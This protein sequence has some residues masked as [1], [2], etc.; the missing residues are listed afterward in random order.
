MDQSTNLPE[1]F[2]LDLQQDA[3][4]LLDDSKDFE[5]WL[6]SVTEFLKHEHLDSLLDTRV[7]RPEPTSPNYQKWERYSINARGW[8]AK[9]MSLQLFLRIE[10]RGYPIHLADEFI[11]NARII[12]RESVLGAVTMEVGPLLFRRRS[13]FK[14]ALEYV[15]A[16]CDH[17]IASENLKTYINPCIVLSRIFTELRREIPDFIEY[18]TSLVDAY[19]DAWNKLII[20]DVQEACTSIIAHLKDRSD[21][22]TAFSLLE[23]E[24]S[25]TTYRTGSERRRR[26]R[27]GKRI[28]LTPAESEISSEPVVKAEP[29]PKT[30][31]VDWAAKIVELLKDHKPLSRKAAL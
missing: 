11:M 8:L 24:R 9:Q 27:R 18:R 20:E 13:D 23:E 12:L 30:G 5:M 15:Q 1:A 6:H 26:K 16:T 31:K 25:R 17:Y 7:A 3:I 28:I 19:G 4:Y 29:E 10:C 14:T 2:P 22:T 21:P